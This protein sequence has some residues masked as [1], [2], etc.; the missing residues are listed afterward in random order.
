MQASRSRSRAAAAASILTAAL[1]LAVASPAAIGAP[2]AGTT[3]AAA[4]AAPATVITSGGA[5]A[6]AGPAVE[7][8]DLTSPAGLRISGTIS[9]AAGA[10]PGAVVT[11]CP[12]AM[13]GP[14]PVEC[15]GS[16][17]TAAGAYSITGLAPGAYLVR[18]APPASAGTG[19][20]AGYVGASGYV[21]ARSAASKI[22]I[23]ADR[24]GVDLTL[25]AGA[26]ITGTV[27]SQAGS[28]VKD[29]FVEACATD[30]PAGIACTGTFAGADGTFAVGGLGS[31]TYWIGIQAPSPSGFASGY[32][33]TSGISAASAGAR[34]VAAGTSGLAIA[35]PA[36]RTFSGTVAL[37]GAGAPGDVIVQACADVACIYGP[38]TLTDEDGRFT[39]RGVAPGTW[40]VV[41]TMNG[42][43]SHVGGYR[44]DGGYVP[45]RASA[46]AV[47]VG[48]SGVVGMDATLPRA[49]A[50]IDGTATGGG[51]PLRG[52][53]V[54]A[55]GAG[56]S[57]FW[58][59][60]SLRDGT[61]SLALPSAGPWTVGLR[62]PGTYAV[63]LPLLWTTGIALPIDSR[64]TDG[65]LGGS[66]FT[67]S[68]SA[69]R[70]VVV[71]SPDRT[72]P[73]IVA[74]SPRPNATKVAITT[75]VVVAFSEPVTGVTA[76][77]IVLRD[78]K[79]RKAVAATV[80][81]D[82]AKRTATL[83]PRKALAKGRRYQV[84]VA[85]TIADYA[86]NRLAPATWV[87]ATKP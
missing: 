54:V 34:K 87:F 59:Q 65:Y 67:A 42:V 28:P 37:E 83:T 2:S 20:A 23:T 69:A 70:A 76:K 21:A 73:A 58:T 39:I 50:R 33:S 30:A 62:A 82:T 64:A 81:Y 53:V 25:P 8:A 15:K 6:A 46:T 44:G 51:S 36:G 80:T 7:R 26:T 52:G 74:R 32:L 68:A 31:G 60:T 85:G 48:G 10:L 86:G 11:A 27:Q 79:T 4:G 5:A 61:Y 22:A 19:A 29:A 17:T 75:K 56:S 16:L 66:G 13:S 9:G 3:V 45:N 84:V 12:V 72:K 71:G 55:C 35:L 77:S 78:A 47:K 49:V 43:A 14:V 63:G 1:W 38:A 40:T 24:S 57:C 41:Y 18:A